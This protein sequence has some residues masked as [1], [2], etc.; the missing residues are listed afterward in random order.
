MFCISCVFH[1]SLKKAFACVELLPITAGYGFE[2]HEVVY[3]YNLLLREE[4]P[5]SEP[6]REIDA[7]KDMVPSCYHFIV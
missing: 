5:T 7:E 3:K 1:K 4:Q 2:L 6:R